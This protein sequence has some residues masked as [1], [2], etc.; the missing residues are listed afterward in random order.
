M[1]VYRLWDGDAPGAHGSTPEDIPT[2]TDYGY[3]RPD[4]RPA[5]VVCPG[6]GYTGLA[7][8]EGAPIAHWLESIGI[9]ALVLKYRLGNTYKHPVILGDAQ[10]AIRF[11]RA[12]AAEFGVDPKKVGIIGFSAGGHLTSMV[13]TLHDS[14]IAGD[15]IDAF[16]CRPDLAVLIYPVIQMFGPLTHEFSRKQLIG[17]NFTE[18]QAKAVSSELNVSLDTCA[19]FLVHTTTDDVVPVGNS[20]VFASALAGHHIPFELH[21]ME[22]GPHGFGMG[23][24]G[25]ALDWRPA[26]TKW[27]KSHG[28]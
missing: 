12:N 16:S 15:H 25:G 8:H 18:Q 1:K 6:G 24:P 17:A 21:V 4:P 5:I 9:R 2:L 14:G 7:D 26:C 10:R 11:V 28:F 20:L 22:R 3:G 13:A 27:L 19:S 23:D